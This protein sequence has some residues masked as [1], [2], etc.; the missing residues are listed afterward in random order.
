[1]LA[2]ICPARERVVRSEQFRSLLL[3]FNEKVFIQ[4]D[5]DELSLDTNA[6]FFD[7]LF[8]NVVIPFHLREEADHSIEKRQFNFVHQILFAFSVYLRS[9]AIDHSFP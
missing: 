4:L 7:L 1:M 8:I 3:V 6:S 9:E 2:K 5:L